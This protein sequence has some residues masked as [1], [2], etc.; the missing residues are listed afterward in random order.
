MPLESTP[1]FSTKFSWPASMARASRDIT[2][3]ALLEKYSNDTAMKI[4][5]HW[6]S[7]PAR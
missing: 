1:M 4:K 7:G 5:A 2:P 6:A 3:M